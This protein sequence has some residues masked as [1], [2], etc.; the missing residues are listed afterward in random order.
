[1]GIRLSFCDKDRL[2]QAFH[3]DHMDA[4]SY[5]SLGNDRIVHILRS[6]VL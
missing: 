6:F 3:N 2:P 4:A 5:A 1:M